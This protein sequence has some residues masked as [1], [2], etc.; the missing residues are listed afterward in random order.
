MPRPSVWATRAAL[1]HLAIGF[2]L[3]AILLANKGL[4]LN[5]A[6]WR[7]LPLHREILL[8]GWMAQLAL[9]VAYW[10]LPPARTLKALA[11]ETPGTRGGSAAFAAS[12]ICLNLGVLLAGI[13]PAAGGPSAARLAGPILEATAGLLFAPHA[14]KR[15]TA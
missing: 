13:S 14:W 12:I 5:P 10:I 9:G 6:L 4:G 3:G 11:P 7:L 15:L 8:I 1:L 2:T